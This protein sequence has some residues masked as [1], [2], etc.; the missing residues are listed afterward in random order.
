[1]TDEEAK[2]VVVAYKRVFRS[3]AGQIVMQDLADFCRAFVTC[4]H[5]NDR[6]H[7]VAE[8]RREVWLRITNMIDANLDD[9]FRLR[10]RQEIATYDEDE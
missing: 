7:A 5:E 10:R 9:L 4:F 6:L 1:M 2:A 3:P 8:G